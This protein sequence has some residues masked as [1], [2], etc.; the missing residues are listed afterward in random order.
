M[1]PLA[2]GALCL[3]TMVNPPL[4]VGKFV[5]ECHAPCTLKTFFVDFEK[6]Y[7]HCS[8]YK[9]FPSYPPTTYSFND[10]E[11]SFTHPFPLS[12]QSLYIVELAI[13]LNIAEILLFGRSAGFRTNEALCY[14]SYEAPYLGPEGS[15]PDSPTKAVGHRCSGNLGIVKILRYIRWT[16]TLRLQNIC[17]GRKM[18]PPPGQRGPVLQH[19]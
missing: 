1:G 2:N 4:T 8:R 14:L 18:P 7:A 3:S 5:G 11:K 12:L 19:T 10:S 9:I 16:C 13:I 17:V 15:R 6:E